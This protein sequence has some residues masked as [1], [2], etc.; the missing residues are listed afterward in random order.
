MSN[1]H[2]II[3]YIDSL[4]PYAKYLREDLE[5]A[6]VHLEVK[7]VDKDMDAAIEMYQLTQNNRVPVIKITTENKQETVLVGYSDENKKK[8]AELLKITL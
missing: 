3:I 7:I 1:T 2:K 6:G 4:S 8:I 5:K